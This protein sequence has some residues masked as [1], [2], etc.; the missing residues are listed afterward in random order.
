MIKSYNDI[1][2]VISSSSFVEA[3]AFVIG[4]VEIEEE[5][6]IWFYS[7][8]RGD[9][10]P[11]KI[12][13]GTNIQDFVAVHTATGKSPVTIGDFVTIGHRAIIHGCTIKNQCLIGMGAIILDGAVIEEGSIIGAGAV[14]SENT[15]IPAGSL[16]LGIPARVVKKLDE[17]R[18]QQ[19]KISAENYIKHIPKYKK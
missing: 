11:I 19:I 1:Y 17:S 14:V 3:S 5:S 8:L 16:A 18:I 12:G 2:P 4:N 13:K 7:V 6:S 15:I 10:L 9:I